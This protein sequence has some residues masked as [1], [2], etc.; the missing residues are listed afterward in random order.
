MSDWRKEFP[1]FPEADMPALGPEWE[2]RSWHN[3]MS[4]S[5][6]NAEKRVWLFVL[7]VDPSLRDEGAE[8]F[9][10]F[11]AFYAGHDGSHLTD[12]DNPFAESDDFD[13]LL[14]V[15]TPERE[16]AWIC[17]RWTTCLGLG[18]H[19][20][21]KGEQF[22]GLTSFEQAEYDSNMTRLFE[23][24]PDPYADGIAAWTRAGLIEEKDDR[25]SGPV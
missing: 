18:W 11:S 9:R 13:A 6:L 14:S 23:I 25:P 19:P 5:F 22:E 21:T 3:D 1:D 2:D 17:D 15:L 7:P 4:P 16:R 20:D 24:S 10:R 8:D 12:V